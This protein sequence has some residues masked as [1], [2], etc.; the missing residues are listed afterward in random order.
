MVDE[1]MDMMA[2][3][4]EGKMIRVD[5]QSI[6]KSSRNTSGVYIVKG[7]DVVNIAR[8]PK[9]ESSKENDDDDDTDIETPLTPV[10][11]D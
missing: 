2:L 6:S 3:T 8:C 9:I 4:K 7:D 5:M 10:V 1:N 11:E